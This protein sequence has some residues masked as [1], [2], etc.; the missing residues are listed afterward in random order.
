LLIGLDNSGKSTI[1]NH[2]RPWDKQVQEIAPTVGFGVEKLRL[3]R[4]SLTVFDM[5]GQVSN[6]SKFKSKKK[7]GTEKFHLNLHGFVICSPNYS[8][9]PDH[10][11]CIFKGSDFYLQLRFV[12]SH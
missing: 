7:V 10:P 4:L 1:I 3:E 8:G 6:V 2:L 9:N 11:I 12:F 5:S